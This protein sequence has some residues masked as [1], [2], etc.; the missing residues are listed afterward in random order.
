MPMYKTMERQIKIKISI[1]VAHCQ[2]KTSSPKQSV[3]TEIF[4]L[5]SAVYASSF[6]VSD[7]EAAGA[8][9][10][11]PLITERDEL[12]DNCHL[13]ERN[14]VKPTIYK[15]TLLQLL[16]PGVARPRDIANH[17]S[18]ASRYLS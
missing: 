8:F 3:V 13:F 16:A 18:A 12:A 10:D 15:C 1:I 14:E 11:Y 2:A 4:A 5:R 7:E 9:G 6:S 17:P